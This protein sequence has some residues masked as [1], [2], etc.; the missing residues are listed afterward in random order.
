[1]HGSCYLMG[2]GS[3]PWLNG[4]G[5]TLPG[6]PLDNAGQK[7]DLKRHLGPRRHGRA[8]VSEPLRL[9]PAAFVLYLLGQ[10][11]DSSA[12][13]MSAARCRSATG[14]RIAH[15]NLVKFLP[16]RSSA[17]VIESPRAP[18]ISPRH[19]GARDPRATEC[20]GWLIFVV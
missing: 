14:A 16:R 13:V 4:A 19:K 18:P 11:W 5:K 15:P 12:Q 2:S 9:M 10:G 17:S 6:I 8:R 3:S 7:I 20:R 1:M